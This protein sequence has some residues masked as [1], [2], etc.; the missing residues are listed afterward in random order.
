MGVKLAIAAT[1][2]FLLIPVLIAA[3]VQATV[4]AVFGHGAS[5]P[6]PPALADILGNYLTLYRQ[7]ATV[8][9]GLDW[10]LLAAIGKVETNHGRSTLPGART[11]ENSAGAGGPMQ[12][13]QPT[14]DAVIARHPLPPGGANPPS[15]YNPH[16]AIYAAAYYL[17]DHGA[18]N[19][20]NL[21]QAIFAYNHA[22]WYVRKVLAQAQRYSQMTPNSSAACRSFQ[23][24]VQSAAR[25]FSGE[26]ALIAVTFACA[27]VG[28][29]YVWGGNGDP[30]FDCSG[31]THAAYQA[32]GIGLPRT[33]QTQ[34]NV[35]PLLPSGTPLLP[36]DLV[37]FGT[38]G[39]IHHVGISLGGTLIVNAPTFGQPVQ[40]AD[41]RGFG[42]YAGASR[43]AAT[44]AA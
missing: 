29:P 11:G 41:L 40:V 20:R 27:Q 39:R 35:G 43:P 7:A 28:K 15:R 26:P 34:Y 38:P 6:S 13:L 17:C 25:H 33:A 8:C 5:Q 18:R 32:A 9:P 36:G 2:A 4:S 31:L 3:A 22:D 44:G 1:G 21:Y 14:F 12:F 23:S 30:G 37:F 10:T 16:D 42:D 24:T 19:G